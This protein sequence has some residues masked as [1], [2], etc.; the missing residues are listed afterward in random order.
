MEA[1]DGARL[2]ADAEPATPAGD[3]AGRAAAR[4][5]APLAIISLA[6]PPL[7]AA[8]LIG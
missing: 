7:G 2:T 5:L 3:D 4:R 1:L 6:L 8:L